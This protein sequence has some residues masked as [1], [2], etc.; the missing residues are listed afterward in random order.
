MKASDVCVDCLKGLADRT[1]SLSGGNKDI[2]ARCHVLIEN[3]YKKENTPAYIANRVLKFIKK[4]TGVY[5]PYIFVKKREFD[6]AKKAIDVFV[7]IFPKT[8]EGSLKLSALGNSLDFFTE[9]RYTLSQDELKF[10]GDIDKIEEEIYINGKEVLILGDN[11]GD[12]IFDMPFIETIAEE[13][14]K[15]VYYAVKEHPVQN[16]L[17]MADIARYNFDRIFPNIVST[18]NDEVGITPKDM[19]GKV[20]ELWKSKATVIAKGMGNYETLTEHNA[21][22]PVVYIMKVKCPA[23]SQSVGYEKGTYIAIYK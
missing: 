3:L 2:L 7:N 6:E 17:S 22:R 15:E 20:K 21:G 23:V 14:E 11:V 18:G 1:V 19:K 10:H 9:C 12:F 5:D 16:D 4:K 13:M 8:L